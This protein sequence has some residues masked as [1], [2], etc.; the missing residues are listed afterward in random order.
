MSLC[1]LVLTHKNFDCIV[2][3]A[4]VESSQQMR[5]AREPVEGTHSAEPPSIRSW[6]ESSRIERPESAVPF[7]RTYSATGSHLRLS[8]ETTPNLKESLT[9][10]D[11]HTLL[12]SK[13]SGLDSPMLASFHTQ[14]VSDVN[15]PLGIF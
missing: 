7:A 2:F 3:G 10:L 11:R 15:R 12:N 8:F 9:D 13:H 4:Q 14:K 5:P 1:Y 6:M